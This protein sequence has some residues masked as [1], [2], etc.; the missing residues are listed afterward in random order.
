MKHHIVSHV[1]C[2]AALP[3]YARSLNMIGELLSL[4][5]DQHNKLYVDDVQVVVRDLAAT[6]GVVHIIDGILTARQSNAVFY[7]LLL[8]S[9][10]S[11]FM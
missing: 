1:I 7:I 9:S 3:Q 2:S 4:S 10:K 6:N 11:F 8:I 5:R